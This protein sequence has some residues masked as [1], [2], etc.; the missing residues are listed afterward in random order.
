MGSEARYGF[1]PP[2]SAAEAMEE[3]GQDQ[4]ADRDAGDRVEDG[5]GV[6]GEVEVGARLDVALEDGL[7]ER[8]RGSLL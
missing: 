3:E 4:A 7:D 2:A 6:A 1:F 8:V 5:Q